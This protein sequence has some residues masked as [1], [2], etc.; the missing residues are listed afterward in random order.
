MLLLS[1]L[2][3]ARRVPAGFRVASA[4]TQ[5]L[6]RAKRSAS[7]L[8]HGMDGN[9]RTLSTGRKHHIHGH[10]LF[11]QQAQLYHAA[12]LSVNRQSA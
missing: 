7:D 2:K 3:K 12:P 1:K 5:V 11:P 8:P 6:A 9:L 4:V 10:V